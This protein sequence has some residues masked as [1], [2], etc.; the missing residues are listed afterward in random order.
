MLGTAHCGAMSSR[1][2]L[3][4]ESSR[5]SCCTR[6]G[7][8]IGVRANMATICAQSVPMLMSERFTFLALSM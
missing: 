8:L 3:K 6:S 2:K 4:A 5:K 7:Q 1:L